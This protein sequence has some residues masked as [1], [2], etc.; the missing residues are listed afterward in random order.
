MSWTPQSGPITFIINSQGF[1]SKYLGSLTPLCSPGSSK[2]LSV[3]LPVSVSPGSPG[4]S[5]RGNRRAVGGERSQRGSSLGRRPDAL[6]GLVLW[7][8]G[9]ELWD[10]TWRLREKVGTG[11]PWPPSRFCS[12]PAGCLWAKYISLLLCHVEMMIIALPAG[13]MRRGNK[14]VSEGSASFWAHGETPQ[15]GC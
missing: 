14:T 7:R 2:Y 13:M 10:R 8:W 12:A 9:S 3:G 15:V 11:P 1:I 4:A 6:W 5:K